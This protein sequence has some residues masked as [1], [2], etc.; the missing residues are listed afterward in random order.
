MQTKLAEAQFAAAKERQVWVGLGDLLTLLEAV[1][2]EGKDVH[3]MVAAGIIRPEKMGKNQAQAYN[4]EVVRKIFLAKKAK[5]AAAGRKWP[6][7]WSEL[8]G[9]MNSMV[10][11][12][13]EGQFFGDPVGQAVIARLITLV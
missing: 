2:V 6:F 10:R 8:R 13:S 12:R 4:A 11:E 7:K 9:K 1:E 3:A 5:D